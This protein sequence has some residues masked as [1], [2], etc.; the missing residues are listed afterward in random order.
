MTRWKKGESRTIEIERLGG[1][2]RGRGGDRADSGGGLYVHLGKKGGGKSS[3]EER[4]RTGKCYS[5]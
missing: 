3:E 1:E 4:G 2:E 5:K